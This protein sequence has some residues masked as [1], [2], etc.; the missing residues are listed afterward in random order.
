MSDGQHRLGFAEVNGTRIA[1]EIAGTGEPLILAHAGL[2]DKSMWDEQFLAFAEHFRVVRY[3]LRGFGETPMVEGEYAHEEDLCAL[4][5]DLGI[6]RAH[7]V[8]CSMGACT[9]LD[10]ALVYPSRVRSLSIV[11]STPNGFA[12]A[13]QDEASRVM[14]EEHVAAIRAGDTKRA[15]DV[16]ADY[17]V[18]GPRRR[19]EE[20]APSIRERVRTM[21]RIAMANKV[22]FFNR[23]S[24]RELRPAAVDR[25][26]ELHVPTLVVFGDLD[27]G[28]ILNGSE[29]ML[30]GTAGARKA[31]INGTAHFPN[32]ERPDE[33]NRIVLDFL[34][35]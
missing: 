4:L 34:R 23:V 21:N 22:A 1:Y 28:N 26:A 30:K 35:G 33:F 10:F 7:L 32:M 11:A 13:Q 27:D 15:A 31:V 29:Y 25:L 12:F 9:M 16:E 6:E 3:D 20:V 18:A 19:P 24:E 2:T 17:W 8:G 14:Q 5:D